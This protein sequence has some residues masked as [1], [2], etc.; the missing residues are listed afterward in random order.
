[1]SDKFNLYN[2]LASVVPNLQTPRPSRNLHSKHT[3]SAV[4]TGSHPSIMRPRL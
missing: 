2:L 1:M 3:S 4:R